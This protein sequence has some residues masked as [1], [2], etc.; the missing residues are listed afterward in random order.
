[1]FWNPCKKHN[2]R[3]FTKVECSKPKRTCVVGLRSRV[4]HGEDLFRA[5]TTCLKTAS[6][7]EYS[8]PKRTCVVGFRSKVVHG[9]DEGHYK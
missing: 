2:L 5:I 8:K 4:A 1:M 9:K 3:Q 7:V 6:K